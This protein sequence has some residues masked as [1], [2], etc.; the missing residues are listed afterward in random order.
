VSAIAKAVAFLYVVA[1][2]TTPVAHFVVVFS[3]GMYGVIADSNLS[4][5]SSFAFEVR[6][7]VH[8][9]V[10]AATDTGNGISGGKSFG[11][12]VHG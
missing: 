9:V 5:T 3:P 11:A 8:V 2:P 10:D 1:R 6:R 7:L 4:P 12:M